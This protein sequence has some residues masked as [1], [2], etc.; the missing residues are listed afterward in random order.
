LI[1][2]LREKAQVHTRTTVVLSIPFED[3]PLTP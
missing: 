3:R 1:Q 2:R